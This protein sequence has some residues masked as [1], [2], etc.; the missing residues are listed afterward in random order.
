MSKDDKPKMDDLYDY[1]NLVTPQKILGAILNRPKTKEV[2]FYENI[3]NTGNSFKDYDALEKAIKDIKSERGSEIGIPSFYKCDPSF[4]YNGKKYCSII[5]EKVEDSDTTT[6]T[7]TFLDRSLKDIS[8]IDLFFNGIP[9]I[10]LAKITPYLNVRFLIK[11]NNFSNLEKFPSLENFLTLDIQPSELNNAINLSKIKKIDSDDFKEITN[12][13][14]GFDKETS[15]FITDESIFK[16]P[17]TLSNNFKPFLSLKKVDIKVT[18][19]VDYAVSF[20]EFNLSLTLHDRKNMNKFPYLFGVEHRSSVYVVIEYGWSHPGND[21][22][23]H[24]AYFFNKILRKKTICQLV[25]ASYSFDDIGQINA[26]IKLTTIGAASLFVD[27]FAKDQKVLKAQKQLTEASNKIKGFV[28]N[29]GITGSQLLNSMSSSENFIK[30]SEKDYQELKKLIDKLKGLKKDKQNQLEDLSQAITEFKTNFG[31]DPR[32]EPIKNIINNKF[33]DFKYWRT[34]YRNENDYEP[35][36]EKDGDVFLHEVF[37]FF[38]SNRLCY[39]EDDYIDEVQFIYYNFGKNTFNSIKD[40]SV[41]K[42]KI[43]EEDL[44]NILINEKEFKY[45][46]AERFIK[47]VITKFI[48]DLKTPYYGLVER[49]TN[50]YSSDQKKS[51]DANDS[52]NKKVSEALKAYETTSDFSKPKVTFRVECINKIMRIHVFD[53]TRIFQIDPQKTDAELFKSYLHSYLENKKIAD[54][55]YDG[56]NVY[57]EGVD[58]KGKMTQDYKW[59]FKN[60]KKEYMGY[61]ENDRSKLNELNQK[62]NAVTFDDLKRKY[63]AIYPMLNVDGSSTSMVKSFQL[64]TTMDPATTT[65]LIKENLDKVDNRNSDGSA[66]KKNNNINELYTRIVPGKI[67]LQ[68]VGFPI[69]DIHQTFFIDLST[70]TDADN[71]YNVV[72]VNHSIEP[73]SF[74]TSLELGNKD[75][76]GSYVN[77]INKILNFEKAIKKAEEDQTLQ[78]KKPASNPGSKK[79]KKKSESEIISE[80]ARL[81]DQKIAEINAINNKETLNK[82]KQHWSLD[83]AIIEA[84]K[85]PAQ[86]MNGPDVAEVNKAINSKENELER[87]DVAAKEKERSDALAADRAQIKA[88]NEA[89][90]K[91]QQERAEASSRFRG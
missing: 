44:K 43:F 21:A 85:S 56:V 37:S 50:L 67:S 84:N 87:K 61:A 45:F 53:Q 18:P 17:A 13:K 38:I 68:T 62:Y 90:Q 82:W 51:K 5:S 30:Y 20:E 6:E 14:I 63:K 29:I 16:S 11:T 91:R 79:K 26:E 66:P 36:N 28:D 19:T 15:Y 48:D 54:K 12:Q 52:L 69:A 4:T 55:S 80:S 49:N 23:D 47:L 76:F 57:E 46:T 65:H 24:Y 83:P 75:T 74:K 9:T 7:G 78:N 72:S 42:F 89:K 64:S 22:T 58:S 35:D 71:L 8:N 73:G 39:V 86:G 27:E 60:K 1:F 34:A 81:R 2:E 77:L 40:T 88:E 59:V 31:K 70:N 25:N 32:E 33:E 10:E 41:G 3:I